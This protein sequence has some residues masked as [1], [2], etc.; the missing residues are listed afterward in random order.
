MD[1]LCID[2]TWFSIIR[3]TRDQCNQRN[4]ATSLL[5]YAF[6][7]K[8]WV[9]SYC[10]HETLWKSKLD[11]GLYNLTIYLEESEECFSDWTAESQDL[12]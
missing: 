3:S 11:Q 5:L 12:C 2:W 7:S 9:E 10:E 6:F 1:L 8:I 4:Q